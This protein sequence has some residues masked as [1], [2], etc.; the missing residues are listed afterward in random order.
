M[1][2]NHCDDR[3]ESYNATILQTCTE[4]TQIG[5]RVQIKQLGTCQIK[6]NIQVML[7]LLGR[8]AHLTSGDRRRPP[9]S[10]DRSVRCQLQQLEHMS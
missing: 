10:Q 2:A 7:P 6:L 5:L 4:E 9:S 1:Q 8:L 3:A